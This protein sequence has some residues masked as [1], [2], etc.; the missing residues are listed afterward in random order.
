MWRAP[1]LSF[2]RLVRQLPELIPAVFVL[3]SLPTVVREAVRGLRLAARHATETQ[4]VARRRMFGAE[5]VEAIE[6][7]RQAI[8]PGEE[9]ALADD[10]ERWQASVSVRYDLAPRRIRYVWSLGP[11][12]KLAMPM[13]A[14]APRLTVVVTRGHTA[15]PRLVET[16][17]L[18]PERSP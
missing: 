16:R 11:D 10:S 4:L 1:R 3:A 13:P 7:L 2:R 5:Y 14:D 15:P 8:P 9:V 17:S 12:G 18:L 6:R